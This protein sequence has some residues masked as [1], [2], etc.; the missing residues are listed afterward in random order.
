VFGLSPAKSK[1]AFRSDAVTKKTILTFIETASRGEN[2]LF[3]SHL[4]PNSAINSLVWRWGGGTVGQLTVSMSASDEIAKSQALAPAIV[5]TDPEWSDESFKYL[6][7]VL[8][9]LRDRQAE[10]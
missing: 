9:A 8:Q 3:D 4:L 6:G 10:Q 2:T 1:A 5:D 7:E